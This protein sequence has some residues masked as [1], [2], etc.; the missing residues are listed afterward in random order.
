MGLSDTWSV[1]IEGEKNVEHASNGGA[2][3]CS[4]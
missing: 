1:N 4:R 2:E 3:W